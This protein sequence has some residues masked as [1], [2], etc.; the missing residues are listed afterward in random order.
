LTAEPGPLAG[1]DPIHFDRLAAVED[2]H[3]WFTA[4]NR[5]LAGILSRIALPPR[6]RVLEVGTGTG[7]T[8]R[9][10]ERSYPDATLVGVDLFEEALTIAR[11]R[12]GAHLVRAR[13]EHLPFDRPFDL[14]AAFDVIEHVSDDRAALA[15]LR[16][17]LASG[18]SL[19]LTVPALARLWSRVDDEAHHC[20]RY[21]IA[22][23]SGRL[24]EAGFVIE[25]LTF[26]MASLYPL[27]RIGRLAAGRERGSALM[28]ELRVVPVVNSMLRGLLTLEAS[29]VTSGRNL[30]IGTSLLAV[31]RRL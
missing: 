27:L 31:A 12:T 28:R 4:R 16:S 2:R 11:R 25:R 14:L 13:V 20:R 22:D 6:A 9:V 26:V 23:L 19:V 18:G 24:L 8:L 1:Y 21:E 15:A 5:L 7:N 17:L 3:F 29:A 30:P 10:L